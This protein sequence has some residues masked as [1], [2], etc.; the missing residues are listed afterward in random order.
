[1]TQTFRGTKPG[2]MAFRSNIH[3]KF[4]DYVTMKIL[5][6]LAGFLLLCMTTASTVI[7]QTADDPSATMQVLSNITTS[8]DFVN[9]AS[10][11]DKFE[12][13]TAN[14]AHGNTTNE[15]VRNV[16]QQILDDHS[17][18]GA[19]LRNVAKAAG[20]AVTPPPALDARKQAVVNA[21]TPLRDAEFDAKYIE[22]QIQ[23]HQEGV[24]LFTSYAD[25]GDNAELKAFAAKTLPMLQKHLEMVTALQPK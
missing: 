19:E 11:S 23:A 21:L 4:E 15:A 20:M 14:L 13:D 10:L 12:I 8:S 9:L 7:A 18:A 1:M 2:F 6:P 16:A 3:S 24:A 5:S 17:K 25:K 22:A